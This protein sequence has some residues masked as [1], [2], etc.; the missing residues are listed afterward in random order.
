[1]G[2]RFDCVAG[3]CVAIRLP[4]VL[5]YVFRCVR[6]C[7]ALLLDCRSPGRDFVPVEMGRKFARR[8]KNFVSLT[9]GRTYEG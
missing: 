8:E 1:M 5:A 7:A 6:T 3:G 2:K 4:I 9:W